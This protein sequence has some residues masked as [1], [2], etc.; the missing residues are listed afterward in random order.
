MLLA[1]KNIFKNNAAL[2]PSLRGFCHA[3]VWLLPQNMVDACTKKH[4]QC[5]LAGIADEIG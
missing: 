1:T 5:G 2:I 4:P 3:I